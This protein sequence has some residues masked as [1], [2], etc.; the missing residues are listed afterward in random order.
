[1][2]TLSNRLRAIAAFASKNDA[3]ANGD[4]KKLG[5]E[6]P[7]KLRDD[8][9][10]GFRYFLMHVF[11]QGRRDALSYD[12]I[13]AT[14][15]ALVTESLLPMCMKPAER[16]L[17]LIEWEKKGWLAKPNWKAECNPVRKALDQKYVLANSDKKSH[18]GKQRDREMVLDI[19]RFICERR[20]ASGIPLNI[21]SWAEQLI[22]AGKIE[23]LHNELDAI[24]QVGPKVISLFLRDLIRLLKLEAF[25][26]PEDYRWLQPVDTWVRR[27]AIQLGIATGGDGTAA[28][29]VRV[30]QQAQIDPM[31]FNQGAWFIGSNSLE[32]LLNNLERVQP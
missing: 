27:I 30:C 16:G 14:N 6:Q 29:I 11:M 1:M 19:L 31:E 10:M 22:R 21:V 7:A 3:L 4:F 26:R 24:R 5:I 13:E 9:W 15:S 23:L 25:L 12:F 28:E 17:R 8:W 18:T 20:S 32:V 2:D